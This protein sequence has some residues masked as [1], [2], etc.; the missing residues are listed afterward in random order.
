MDN[1]SVTVCPISV[2]M[3]DA[4]RVTVQGEGI[5]QV[6]VN[7]QSYFKVNTQSAG[8]ADLSVRVT[9]KCWNRGK[10]SVKIYT[11]KNKNIKIKTGACKILSLLHQTQHVIFSFWMKHSIVAFNR[12]SKRNGWSLVMYC[13]Q[14]VP[15]EQLC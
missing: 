7:R 11:S 2:P 1:I 8:D 10:P 4:S 3:M 12:N 13:S 5:R 9:C 6:A 14:P 15:R